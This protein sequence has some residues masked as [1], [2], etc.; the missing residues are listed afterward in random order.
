M[1]CISFW[2]NFFCKMVKC[3]RAHILRGTDIA[4]TLDKELPLL[5]GKTVTHAVEVNNGTGILIATQEHEAYLYSIAESTLTAPVML[6]GRPTAVKAFDSL[7]N[8]FFMGL[9]T[10]NLSIGTVSYT[11]SILLSD[12][13]IAKENAHS[14]QITDIEYTVFNN[15]PF[16]FTCSLDST[17]KAWMVSPD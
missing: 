7:P 10:K 12:K 3:N 6:N 17:V 15:Q 2:D 8:T 4:V 1:G 16:F 11:F 9:E 14:D 5:E 13:S